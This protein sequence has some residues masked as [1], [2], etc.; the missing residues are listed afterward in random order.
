[1]PLRDYPTNSDDIIDSR[2][3]I[4]RLE[5]LEDERQALVDAIEEAKQALEAALL[6]PNLGEDESAKVHDNV[7]AAREALENWDDTTDEGAEYKAL[8]ALSDEAENCSD[9]NHGATLIRESYFVDYCEEL[10]KD[11]GDLPRDMPDYLVIDWEAT[12]RNI[13]VDYSEVDFDGVTYLI[14]S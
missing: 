14:R 8:K 5:E 11:I 6:N 3:V 7:E 9:W 13:R 1:M 4:E 2:N 10:C 12:A